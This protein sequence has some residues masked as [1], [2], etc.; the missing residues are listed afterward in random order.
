M[1]KK[2]SLLIFV[3]ALGVFGLLNTEM[4]VIGI[5][6][7]IATN[8][9]IS[10]STAGLLVSLFALAV[11]IS[12]PIM[13]LLL[14]KFDRKKVLAL[15]LLIFV[16][17][18]VL[19]AFSTNFGLL[20]IARIIPAIF[21]PVYISIALTVAANSVEQAEVPKAT[22]KVIM[23]TSA[24]MVLGVPLATYIGNL[25]GSFQTVM[26]FF[27]IVNVIALIA[28]L[29]VVPSMPMTEKQ[30]YGHQLSVLKEKNTWLSLIAV[31]FIGSAM[32]AVYSYFSVF[33][34]NVSHVTGT[35][36]TIMLIIFGLASIAGNII[37]GRLLSSSPIKTVVIWP[38]AMG[39]LYIVLFMFGK[40]TPAMFI[41]V[42]L[43][44]ILFPIGNNISQYWLV[45]AMPKAPEFGNG[46]FLTAGNLGVTVGTT[47]GG[48]FISSMGT[49]SI[50]I[51]GLIFLILSIIFIALRKNNSIQ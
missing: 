23:G 40:F 45:S 2:N 20:L 31:I 33:L 1:K 48:L 18:N 49:K 38:L 27:A 8:L 11:A 4:G 47:T 21:H 51:L 13:P 26:L 6:P 12:G 34:E 3:L 25:T 41:L 24:G 39:I 43:W 50:V 17:S 7:L 15:S 36:L 28:V 19:S 37:A 42:L 29:V 30:S 22:S 46:L 10:I 5:L 35:T 44:G 14:S 9:H 32:F 16:I